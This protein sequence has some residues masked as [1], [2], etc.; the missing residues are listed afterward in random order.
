MSEKTDV[1]EV[2]AD[3]IE[4]ANWSDID[5][6]GSGFVIDER[7]A[8]ALARAALSA[9]PVTEEMVEAG[10]REYYEHTH[11]MRVDIPWPECHVSY[12]DQR[13][14]AFRAAIQAALNAAVE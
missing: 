13:R 14:N 10:A 11:D 4:G 8:S 1:V 2:V 9:I 5:A 6:Q 12:R 7:L 3:A